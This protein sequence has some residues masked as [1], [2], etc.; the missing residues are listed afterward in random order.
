MGDQTPECRPSRRNAFIENVV[1]C[2]VHEEERKNEAK[3][4]DTGATLALVLES[5]SG[6][7]KS[8]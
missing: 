6:L 3:K 7:M 5:L 4:F 2:V 8:F 1:F